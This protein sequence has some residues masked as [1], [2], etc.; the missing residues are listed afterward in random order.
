MKGTD[1]TQMM[2]A[3][4][5]KAM[6]SLNAGAGVIEVPDHAAGSCFKN[7]QDMEAFA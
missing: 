7:A 6:G 3:V 4:I 1:H 2:G 5:G